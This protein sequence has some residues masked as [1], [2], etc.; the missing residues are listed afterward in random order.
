VPLSGKL[1]LIA[2]RHGIKIVPLTIWEFASRMLLHEKHSFSSHNLPY[3]WELHLFSG[4]SMEFA[5]SPEVK[6]KAFS[7]NDKN[8][9]KPVFSLLPILAMFSNYI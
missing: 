1:P 5:V 8:W 6:I 7:G 3:S 2:V 9:S 4:K